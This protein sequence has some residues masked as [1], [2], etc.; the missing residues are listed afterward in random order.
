MKTQCTEFAPLEVEEATELQ[1]II[2]RAG[3]EKRAV[4]CDPDEEGVNGSETV[5]LLEPSENTNG[6]VRYQRHYHQ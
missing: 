2:N 1:E 4:V 6:L 3:R 5:E